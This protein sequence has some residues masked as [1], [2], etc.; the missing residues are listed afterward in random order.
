MQEPRSGRLI[1][2]G[3]MTN[4]KVDF[5]KF[6]IAFG[7]PHR[8][9]HEAFMS[10]LPK[11]D[12]CFRKTSLWF[13]YGAATTKGVGDCGSRRLAARRPTF[14]SGRTYG[15]AS[16]HD[17]RSTQ[18][19]RGAARNAFRRQAFGVAIPLPAAI[20]PPRCLRGR[21]RSRQCISSSKPFCE[22]SH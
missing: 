14:P 19:P 11:I 18:P 22:T 3:M 9:E 6:L 20:G 21:S 1:D 5:G 8:D 12:V 16:R 7:K 17:P 10:R 2:D 4:R 15:S 13:W